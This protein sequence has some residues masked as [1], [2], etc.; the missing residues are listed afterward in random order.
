MRKPFLLDISKSQTLSTI[1]KPIP[2]ASSDS[3]KVQEKG[4]PLPTTPDSQMTHRFTLSR[5]H[6]VFLTG[7]KKQDERRFYEIEATEQSW[8]LRGFDVSTIQVFI[9]D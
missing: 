3:G 9:S 6:Y 7:I 4:L 2:G 1:S 8:S 5:S